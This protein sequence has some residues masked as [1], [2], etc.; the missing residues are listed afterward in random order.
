MIFAYYNILSKFFINRILSCLRS[1]NTIPS[2]SCVGYTNLICSLEAFIP[3]IVC[4]EIELTG[5]T[6]FCW[7]QQPEDKKIL[8][9]IKIS[10]LRR[11]NFLSPNCLPPFWRWRVRITFSTWEKGR[12][13]EE[14]D[15]WQIDSL[16]RHT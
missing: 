14:R 11:Q 13:N 3:F 7:S 16:L 1:Q 2:M 6:C 12:E 4:S 9:K 8:I 5:E 10:V 15:E